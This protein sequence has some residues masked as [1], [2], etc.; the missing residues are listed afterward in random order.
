M[1]EVT[2]PT[3]TTGGVEQVDP[4]SLL[5]DVNVRRETLADK[6]FVASVK[7]LA[8]CSRSARSGPPTPRCGWRPV[9]GGRW[10]RSRPGWR[11]CR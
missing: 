9:T 7:D 10:P 1:A 5:V 2:E 4:S 8:C 3:T 11:R 6:D